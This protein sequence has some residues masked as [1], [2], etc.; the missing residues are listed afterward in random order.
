MSMQWPKLLCAERL[1]S[2]RPADVELQRS[3]FQRDSDRLIFSSA[4]RRLQD[5][6]QVFP[7]A[8]ND[9]VR[10]RLTHSLEVASV[11]RS[12]GA[13]VG[14]AICERGEL[15]GIHAS[16][17]GAIVSAAALAHDLGNP[18]F[19]HSGED[20]IRVWFE[21]SPVAQDA[22]TPLR[23]VEQ[24][25]LARFEGNAQGFRVITRLQMPDNPGLRLTHATL[26]AFT[27]YSIE[28]LVPDKARVHEGAS[29]KKFGFFQSEREFFTEVADR[30]GLIRR[31]PLHAWW[32]RHPLA[33]LVE[34]ADDICYR[35]VD[36]ED[37]FRL[38]FLDYEEIC[39][40]FVRVI[41][42]PSVRARAEQMH[43]SKERIEF[44]RAL[45]IGAAV[46]QTAEL[47]LEKEPEILRGEFDQPLIDLIPAGP[48]LEAIKRRSVESIYSTIRGVEI[49]AAGFAVLGGLLDDFVA[50]VSD[51]ARRGKHAS[52]RSQKL[53]RLVPEQSLGPKREPD[54]N[55]Y[56]RLLR[57]IDFV[58]G[59]TDT[60]AVSLYKKVRG[61]SLPG[62]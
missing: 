45:A 7:L 60:Y 20:A 19:G 34:A 29:T 25:D 31:T 50:A 54:P 48:E 53:L 59:M 56:Q 9:Y 43:E 47:F 10:T 36:F 27:K 38:G 33:F 14:A 42:D 21:K 39:E 3:P 17:F 30:C 55:P 22:R 62:Q 8:N 35:L 16:D 46:Q 40:R 13:I 52:P 32:T 1:G 12:L 28:S 58:S 61:I 51:L 49:E 57:M 6:T 41:G 44:L 24:E 2:K 18:P 11:G 37:G 5:K 15:P 26:G 4:F 23:K